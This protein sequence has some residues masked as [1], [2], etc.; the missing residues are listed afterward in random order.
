MLIYSDIIGY[1]SRTF[2]RRC[3]ICGAYF[4]EPIGTAVDANA[5]AKCQICGTISSGY[6]VWTESAGTEAVSTGEA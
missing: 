6:G 4:L 1:T 3:P 5:P 2:D